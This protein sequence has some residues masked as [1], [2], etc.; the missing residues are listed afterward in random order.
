MEKNGIQYVAMPEQTYDLDQHNTAQPMFYPI[1]DKPVD[2]NG[3]GTYE[4]ALPERPGEKDCLHY[5]RHGT[6]SYGHTCKYHHPA[7]RIAAYK[8]HL[9][10]AGGLANGPCPERPGEPNCPYYMKTGTCRYGITCKF[11]HPKHL[12]GS[13]AAPDQKL[14][15]PPAG[16][17]ALQV[18]YLHFQIFW[19]SGSHQG[20]AP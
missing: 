13:E 18:I 1:Y 19:D 14:P 5:L 20:Q 7:D 3:Y 12:G 11:S 8:N 2:M 15:P 10:E 9:E 6:C 17:N 4:S 16:Y